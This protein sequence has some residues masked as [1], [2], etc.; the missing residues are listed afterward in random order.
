MVEY[1]RSIAYPDSAFR[2]EITGKVILRVL[3]D[4]LGNVVEHLVM[5][6]PH[7]LLTAA[8]VKALPVLRFSPGMLKGRKV[9]AW[10]T[11][12][13]ISFQNIS[14]WGYPSKDNKRQGLHSR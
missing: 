13:P 11:L 6:D 5:K 7:P 2:A 10:H 9:S 1:R 14:G 8:T 3:V 12:P 4:T